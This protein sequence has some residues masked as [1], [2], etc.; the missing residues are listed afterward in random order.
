MKLGACLWRCVCLSVFASV[1]QSLL[2]QT[3]FCF[4][5]IGIQIKRFC[6]L[7]A[8][9]L[10]WLHHRVPC[11]P[12]WPFV[13]FVSVN[14]PHPPP[15][16]AFPL[17]I[18]LLWIV[19]SL[20]F[21]SSTTHFPSLKVKSPITHFLFHSHESLI[22][23]VTSHQLLSALSWFH[24]FL[25]LLLVVKH[26]EL[27]SLAIVKMSNESLQNKHAFTFFGTIFWVHNKHP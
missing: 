21:S 12:Q 20:P 3:S 7:W 25:L 6:Q 22:K 24:S 16:A 9:D 10:K 14:L 5:Y 8:L 17:F 27:G 1:A 2:Y 23:L 11:Q 19:S 15:H 26:C 13:T 18:P 4:T